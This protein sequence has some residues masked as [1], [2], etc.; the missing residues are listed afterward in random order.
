MFPMH[1]LDLAQ[2]LI[3]DRERDARERSRGR[4]GALGR[5]S[6][7]LGSWLR[8]HRAPAPRPV[9]GVGTLGSRSSA[10]AVAVLHPSEVGQLARLV[11]ACFEDD[12]QECD[13]PADQVTER[14]A[15]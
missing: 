11:D 7:H 4:T 15:S 10:R 2:S 6:G 9:Q 12:C 1:H 8:R 3:R 5:R 14:A 13:G